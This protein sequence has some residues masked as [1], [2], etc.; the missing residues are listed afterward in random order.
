LWADELITVALV[1]SVS[2]KHMF[3]A[4]LLGLDATPPLYTGYGWLMW[5]YLFPESSPEWL[6]RLT[7]GGLI[8]ATLWILYLLVRRY[9]DH[10]TALITVCAFILLERLKLQFLTLE[11]RSYAALVFLTALAIYASLRAIER[12]SPVSL[13]C[14]MLAYSLL[15]CSHTFGIIYV[16]SIAT[17][18]I[19]ASDR[20]DSKLALTAGLSAIPAIVMFVLWVPVLRSQSQLGSWILLPD[21]TLLLASA[22]LPMNKT[23]VALLSLAALTLL[24]RLTRGHKAPAPMLWWR[25]LNFAQRFAILLPIAFG[26]S[27][28]AVWIFSRFVFPVFVTRFFYP[29]IILHTIWLS[30]LVASIFNYV[31]QSIVRYGLVPAFAVLTGLTIRYGQF[32]VESRIPCFD[33]IQMTYIEDAFKGNGVIVT[34]GSHLWLT[35]QGRPGEAVVFPIDD[36]AL[37]KNGTVYGPYVYHARFV[38]R[39]AEWSGVKG[40]LTTS[41]LL[42]IKP[43]LMVLD[44]DSG[45]GS[46]LNYIQIS[47]K[48]KLMPLAKMNGCTLWR[49]ETLQ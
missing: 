8:G 34:Q 47:H 7:N 38:M 26:S 16:I 1:K 27:T 45:L 18:A 3:S 36:G 46:W 10:T 2:L 12:P 39:F 24:W 40:I 29:N 43:D 44:D 30:V 23:L 49:M 17:C 35:R 20:L 19:G 21:F 6:L 4:I 31:T 48:V 28:A 33:P 41:Q 22:Q 42:N 9:F 13:T 11:V 25:S 5:H 15:V 14:M 32:G 37:N